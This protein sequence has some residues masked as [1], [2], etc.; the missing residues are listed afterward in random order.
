[1]NSRCIGTCGGKAGQPCLIH[2]SSRWH[3]IARLARS[4]WQRHHPCFRICP[5]GPW[6]YY[7]IAASEPRLWFCMLFRPFQGSRM[8]TDSCGALCHDNSTDTLFQARW[9]LGRKSPSLKS[10]PPP[11]RSR[12]SIWRRSRKVV[13]ETTSLGPPRIYMHG[14]AAAFGPYKSIEGC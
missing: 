4:G 2:L 6:T 9:R 10:N 13:M 12:A 7:W 1:M 8:W 5:S 11:C 14:E 3:I